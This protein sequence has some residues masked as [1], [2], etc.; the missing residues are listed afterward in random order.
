LIKG[1]RISTNEHRQK[2]EASWF[3]LV[4]FGVKKIARTIEAPPPPHQ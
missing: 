4:P 1:R 2:I 3:V